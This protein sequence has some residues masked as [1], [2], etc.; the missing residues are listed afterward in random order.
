M[1]R[2]RRGRPIPR[3]L[4]GRTPQP[5]PEQIGPPG[6]GGLGVR[7]RVPREPSGVPRGLAMVFTTLIIVFLLP[8]IAIALF[9]LLGLLVR[10]G[11]ALG[12]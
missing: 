2:Y 10:V 3:N 1:V 6:N 7:N 8:F 9:L 11:S 4:G 12:G 5:N